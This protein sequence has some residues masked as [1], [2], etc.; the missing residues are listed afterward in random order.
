VFVDTACFIDGV[1]SIQYN[2]R[3]TDGY[4][5]NGTQT[6]D[7]FNYT[8][9]GAERGVKDR[10]KVSLYFNGSLVDSIEKDVFFK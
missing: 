3:G 10:N 2:V 1:S 8:V 4:T 9:P 5:D 6:S 7:S